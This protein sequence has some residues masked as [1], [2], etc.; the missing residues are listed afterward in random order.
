MIPDRQS[1]QGFNPDLLAPCGINCR[2]CGAFFRKKRAC[3]GCHLP[4]EYKSSH[5]YSC[6]IK[7]CAKEKGLKYCSA[8]TDFPCARI[9]H[10]NK[11]YSQKYNTNLIEN[12]K[13]IQEIGEE[14]FLLEEQS[15]WTCARCGGIICMHSLECSK[16]GT[17]MSK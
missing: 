16:C 17:K 7:N 3:P 10:I 5:C 13:R 12:A 15:K 2:L 1:F 6:M 14:Q 4:G 8:C 11:R 9:K